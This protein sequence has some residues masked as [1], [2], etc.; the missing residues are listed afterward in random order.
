MRRALGDMNMKALATMKALVSTKALATLGALAALAALAGGGVALSGCGAS[1]TLD[2]LA[3][4]AEV[5]SQQPGAKVAMTMQL[6]APGLPGGSSFA[7]TAEG[8]F[9]EKAHSGEMTMDLSQVPGI[10]ALGGGAGAKV[11]MVF[12]YPVVYMNMPFLAGKLP[13]GKTW[14]KLDITKAMQA[15]GLNAGSLGSADQSD[16]T[17]FL[18][19]LKASSGGVVSLGGETVDGVP[20]T[21]YRASLQLSHILEHLSGDEQAMV[22]GAIEKLG[23]AGIIPVDAWVDAQGRVRRMQLSID[24]LGAAAGVAA[25]SPGATSP[26]AAGAAQSVSM[27]ITID[28]KSYGPGPAI[29][30]PPADEVFDASALASGLK[31]A[32]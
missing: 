19:Y 17:Q 29:V 15:A 31:P 7:M 10:S 14:M 22:K 18:Q 2:P 13:E 16:P 6:S 8:W 23:S 5:T 28:F 24:G 3:R 9:D 26:G 1:A 25:G 27:A 32:G 11:Q 4:A 20:T 30:A 12:L 21:H